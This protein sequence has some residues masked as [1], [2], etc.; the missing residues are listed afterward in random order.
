MRQIFIPVAIKKGKEIS[1]SK[2]R[3]GKRYVKCK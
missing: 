2:K 3:K 1:F